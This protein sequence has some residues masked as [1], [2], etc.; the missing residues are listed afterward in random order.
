MADR[1]TD[2]LNTEIDGQIEIQT[3]IW[4]MSDG[5]IGEKRLIDRQTDKYIHY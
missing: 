2:E 4:M 5:Q 3:E 1:Q